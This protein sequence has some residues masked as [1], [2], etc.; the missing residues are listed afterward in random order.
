MIKLIIFDYDGVIVDSFSNIYNVYRIICKKLDKRFPKNIDGFRKIYGY[1]YVDALKNLGI[2]KND[3][4][5]VEI[6]FKKEIL[7][8][9]PKMFKGVKYILKKLKTNYKLALVSS[10][11]KEEV[12]NKLKKY[13]IIDY[14]DII[15]TKTKYKG[16][17]FDKTGA[18]VDIIKKFKVRNYEVI[19]IGD[20]TV[21]YD[22]GLEAG[23]PKENIILVEYGWGYDPKITKSQKIK[24]KNPRDLMRAIESKT[25]PKTF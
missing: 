19:M 10:T 2:E 4:T 11:Y 25:I 15:K 6:I 8:Q 18:I 17:H 22:E 7:K 20:R 3:H 14:F 13:R 24:I 5:K 16:G 9:E 12:I 21:D 23:I 1:T